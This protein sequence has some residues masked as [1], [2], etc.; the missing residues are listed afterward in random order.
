MAKIRYV[1]GDDKMLNDVRGMWEALNLYHCERS[2]HFKKHYL[3]MTFQKR[4]YQL[5]KK[6]V[7]GA[8]SVDIAVD[9]STGQ[10][11]GYIISSV[12]SEKTGEIESVYVEESYRR[13]GIGSELMKT[14]LAWMDEKC[15]ITKQVEVSVGNESAWAFYGQF[16]F[17]PRKTLLKQVKKP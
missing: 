3:E 9:E 6:T 13:M 10:S 7:L 14:A 15:A 11:I 1:H 8:M 5:K 17:L 12:N 16:G 4:K 2:A